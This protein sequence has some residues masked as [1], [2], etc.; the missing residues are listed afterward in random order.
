MW[1]DYKAVALPHGLRACWSTPV[2]DDAGAVL[3]TFAMY[4]TE[5]RAPNG[6]ELALARTAST[7][8]NNIIARDRMMSALRESEAQMRAARGEAEHANKMKSD[9][10]AMMSHELRTPLNAIGG[11][12]KLLLEGI[13]DPASAGQEN[14]LNRIVKAQKHLVELIDAVLTHAKLEAGRMTYRM[15]NIPS[16]SCSTWSSRSPAAA[17]REEHQLRL[18]RLRCEARAARRSPEGRADHAQPDV[19]RDQVHARG[20]SRHRRNRD[21]RERAPRSAYC[22]GLL[23]NGL[24]ITSSQFLAASPESHNRLHCGEIDQSQQQRPVQ[25]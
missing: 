18:R 5:T 15:E 21:P 1:A 17:E 12:A 3:G 14:Y 20:R 16:P 19:E 24:K 2:F 22:S 7:L 23:L 11:Y 9:F 10:L 6:G 25:R 8:V 13:P 4:Y